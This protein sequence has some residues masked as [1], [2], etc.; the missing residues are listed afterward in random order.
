MPISIV[1]TLVLSLTGVTATSPAAP[2]TA[3]SPTIQT[4]RAPARLAM[5]EMPDCYVQ[6]RG[7]FLDIEHTG[8]GEVVEDVSFCAPITLDGVSKVVL[9]T[10]I[11]EIT[12]T[13]S[14][15]EEYSFTVTLL[16]GDEP[17][18]TLVP[19]SGHQG[20]SA[21]SFHNFI[22]Q[23]DEL[24]PGAVV[25]GIRLTSTVTNPS[26]SV[27][28]RGAYEDNLVNAHFARGDFDNDACHHFRTYPESAPVQII[29]NGVSDWI[30]NDFED[31]VPLQNMQFIF[32]ARVGFTL[33][34]SH[35]T[36]FNIEA[37]L[38]LDNGDFLQMDNWTS[39][40]SAAPPDQPNVW[41]RDV[42]LGINYPEC[43]ELADRSVVGWR[44]RV[45]KANAGN[46]TILPPDEGIIWFLSHP[47]IKPGD[48]NQDGVVDAADLL[49]VLSAWGE[50]ANPE[51]CPADLTGDC[52]VDVTDFL[53]VLTGWN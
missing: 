40:G 44:W 19:A 31:P 8:G 30:Q 15:I 27:W 21:T 49:I 1:H 25:D 43:L 42:R 50:C 47:C 10:L 41:A 9:D 36:A 13:T 37:Q 29:G 6:T 14:I 20:G 39:P 17:V 38:L 12:T 3:T 24:S 5:S 33:S 4:H 46:L 18:G 26:L 35:G 16:S 53:A 45:H 7:F 22:L 2:V 52:I 11:V 34:G 51:Y 28:Y 23:S 32:P 48:L